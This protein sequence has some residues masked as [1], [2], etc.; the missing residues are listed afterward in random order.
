MGLRFFFL[1]S[2]KLS[3]VYKWQENNLPFETGKEKRPLVIDGC[4]L[5]LWLNHLLNMGTRGT[6]LCEIVVI[7]FASCS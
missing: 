7:I 1:K 6:L 4:E 2:L 5:K 3:Q